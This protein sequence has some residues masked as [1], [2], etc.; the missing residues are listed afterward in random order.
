MK[1]S[2]PGSGTK[3]QFTGPSPDMVIGVT[4]YSPLSP[5]FSPSLHRNISSPHSPV[6][7]HSSNTSSSFTCTTTT[8]V[9]VQPASS[10]TVTVYSV[11]TSGHTSMVDTPAS[12][13]V[14]S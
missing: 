2:R 4:T 3:F 1:P 13:V 8:P 7:V 9:P 11:S 5:L 6:L 12:P 14:H 10:V